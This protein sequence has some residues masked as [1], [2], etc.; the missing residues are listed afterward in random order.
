M[1]VESNSAVNALADQI[2]A[3]GLV[4]VAIQAMK[5]SKYFPW[6]NKETDKISRAFS[7]LL[8]AAAAIGIHL[9]WNHGSV[10]GSYMLQVSGLTLTGILTGCWAVTKS[11]VFNEITY[12]ATVKAAADTSVKVSTS[13]PAVVEVNKPSTV[14]AK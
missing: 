13:A 11:F 8:A 2:T 10:P 7:M 6:I 4:V 1:F 5:K 3:S 12:R 14:V 9:A